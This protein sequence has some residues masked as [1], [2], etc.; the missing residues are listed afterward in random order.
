MG[1]ATKDVPLAYFDARGRLSPDEIATLV[2]QHIADTN[3]SSRRRL[4]ESV[5]LAR[6]GSAIGVLLATS[7]L[8]VGVFAG[9]NWLLDGPLAATSVGPPVA[10]GWRPDDR[11]QTP[12]A[13]PERI[14]VEV[15]GLSVTSTDP[16]LAFLPP[17]AT[18]DTPTPPSATT[19]PAVTTTTSTTG[20]GSPTTTLSAQTTTPISITTTTLVTT[21]TVPPTTTTTSPE[22]TTTTTPGTTTTSS[23]LSSTTTCQGNGNC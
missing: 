22:P 12:S 9:V 2:A 21:A 11:P 10:S 17:A 19:S 13:I 20:A 15:L 16:M 8:V 7:A 6:L 1:T 14:A 5:L 4:P 18:P 3:R 23:P